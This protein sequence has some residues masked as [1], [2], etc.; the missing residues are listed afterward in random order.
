MKLSED[1][2]LHTNVNLKNSMECFSGFRRNYR[3]FCEI[4]KMFSWSFLWHPGSHWRVQT[5][6][7]YNT[8]EIDIQFLNSRHYNLLNICTS[9]ESWELSHKCFLKEKFWSRT[10][11]NFFFFSLATFTFW[12]QQKCM[13]KGVFWNFGYRQVY[14]LLN[15][16]S[17]PIL[18]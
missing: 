17:Y 12:I 13:F 18:I 5:L 14:R 16:S 11:N 9:W 8:E 10:L 3:L 15:S 6:Q 2:R 7:R 1:Q 4:F